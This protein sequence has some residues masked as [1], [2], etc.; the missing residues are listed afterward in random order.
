MLGDEHDLVLETSG[1]V[2]KDGSGI[3]GYSEPYSINIKLSIEI[4]NK[5]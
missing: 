2:S 4:I 1:G 5:I 3:R